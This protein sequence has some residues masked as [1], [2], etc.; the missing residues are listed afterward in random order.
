MPRFLADE[1]FDKRILEGL[2]LRK[3]NVDV[4]RVQDVGLYGRKDPTVLDWAVKKANGK[5][6]SATCLC[7]HIG[8]RIE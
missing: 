2:F 7:E 3:P 6:K 5:T 1:N 8:S 4:V